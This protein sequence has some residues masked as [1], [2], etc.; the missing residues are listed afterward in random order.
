MFFLA[1]HRPLPH[2]QEDP[3]VGLKDE[4][5]GLWGQTR[6]PASHCLDGVL[7]QRAVTVCHLP[8]SH[9]RIL[10]LQNL[11][12]AVDAEIT[13]ESLPHVLTARTSTH[14]PSQSV[15]KSGDLG[16]NGSA[17][18]FKGS[19]GRQRD[20][21]RQKDRERQR[22]PYLLLLLVTFAHR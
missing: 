7:R 4:E 3:A 18:S 20:R 19:G 16:E 1:L 2:P 14:D 12:P 17:F 13:R 9:P 6:T 22:K 11:P 5:K 21:E 10:L 8:Q 15:R